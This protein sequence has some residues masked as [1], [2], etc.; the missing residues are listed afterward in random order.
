MMAGFATASLRSATAIVTPSEYLA[1]DRGG[2]LAGPADVEVIPNGVAVPALADPSTTDDRLSVIFVGR[3][4][5][6][7][8][9]GALIGGG[10]LHGRRASLGDRVRAGRSAPSSGTRGLARSSASG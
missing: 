8:A 7:E 4:V 10:G 1:R 6:H 3:L 9:C 5:S 2:W